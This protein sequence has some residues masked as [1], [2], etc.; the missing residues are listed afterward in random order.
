[1]VKIS[2]RTRSDSCLAGIRT[3]ASTASR[4]HF[5]RAWNGSTSRKDTMTPVFY[6]RCDRPNFEGFQ[7]LLL[8]HL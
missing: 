1:M 7:G 5:F 8:I 6:K 4:T 3:E 2:N